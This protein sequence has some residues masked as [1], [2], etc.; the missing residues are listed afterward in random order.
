MK[1]SIDTYVLRTRYGDE[2]AFRMLKEAGFEAVDYSFNWISETERNIL[3]DDYVSYAYEVKRMLSENNLVCNQAHAPFTLIYTDELSMGNN[4]YRDVVRSMEFASI[5]GAE[6]I[7]V[8]GIYVPEGDDFEAL[9][10]PYFKSLEP[11]CKK[12]G[13]KI[14]VENIFAF[15]KKRNNIIG[16]YGKESDKLPEFIQKLDSEWFVA[17]ID[18]GHAALTGKEPEEIILTMKNKNLLKALHVQDTDYAADRHILPFMGNLNWDNITKALADVDYHGD[19]S[20][21]VFQYLKRHDDEFMSEALSYAAKTA[22]YV[23]DKINGWR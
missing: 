5:I 12:F 4:K 15:D 1:I 21:E 11:Y 6:C 19:V 9:N 22:K 16:V 3:D 2:K 8:H 10:I 18:I 14:A 7:V 17:C 23:V 20:L 13:I